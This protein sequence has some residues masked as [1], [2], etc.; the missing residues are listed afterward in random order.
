MIGSATPDQHDPSEVTEAAE[1]SGSGCKRQRVGQDIVEA[2]TSTS[3]PTSPPGVLEPSEHEVPCGM[4]QPLV[5][6]TLEFPTDPALYIDTP[7]TPELTR[8][9]LKNGPCQPGLN[10]EFNFERNDKGR[11]FRREWYEPLLK[12]RMKSYREWLIYSPRKKSAFCFP[13]W[14]FANR[15]HK[16]FEPAFSHPDQ[17]FNSWKKAT[18]SFRVHEQ[19]KVHNDAVQT[20][21][22]TKQH[23][24]VGKSINEEQVRARERQIKQN[25]QVLCRLL[26]IT[27]FLAKQNLA[28]RGH[29][30]SPASKL[31][32]QHTCGGKVQNEGNFLELVK[33][34]SK[35][36]GILAHHLA[37]APKNASYLSAQI[38]NEYIN[39]LAGSVRDKIIQE[40]QTALYYGVI[41]DS[42][43]DISHTDQFSFCLRYVDE[44]FTIQERFIL[45]TEFTRLVV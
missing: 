17:G 31:L 34:L 20:M 13:C 5:D 28:F 19:S 32:D 26:D 36:D 9:I 3:E 23:V 24:R 37:T 30:E 35:Y 21:I 40:V 38:Q 22:Q 7:M 14:L 43:I 45:F 1:P 6:K 2:G 11:A 39:C 41:M 16:D 12:H 4:K 29:T 15:G 33:L 27:L 18:E 44:T 10:N 8:E 25:R 42:T